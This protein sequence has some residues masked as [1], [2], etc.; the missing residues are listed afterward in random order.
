MTAFTRDNLGRWGEM[1]PLVRAADAVFRTACPG[2][3]AAQMAAVRRTPPD[4]VIPGTAFTTVTVNRNLRT[5]CHKDSGDLAAGFGVISVLRAGEY[6]GGHL[7]FPKYRVAVD[8]RSRDVLLADVHECHG[9]TAIVGEP[10]TYERV[11]TVY[12]FRERMTECG[13]AEEEQERAVDR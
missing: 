13:S 6:A 2:R 5:R 8:L 7:V 3:Y 10:G 12:Y 1:L 11:S 4:F 9:N